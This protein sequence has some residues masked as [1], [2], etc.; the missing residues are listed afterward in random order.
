MN[1]RVSP[2]VHAAA[3]ALTSSAAAFA[4]P[5]VVQAQTAALSLPAMPLDQALQRITSWS[6]QSLNID[7]D[8]VRTLTSKPV[9]DAKS[10]EDAVRQATDGLPIARQR[11]DDGSLTIAN[12]IVVIASRDE[13]ETNVLVRGATTS[14]RLGQS[15]RDQARNTQVISSKLLEQQQARTL[16]E[17]LA[18][19]GG[20]TVNATTIQ[21]GVSYT[22]RGF[23]SNG[24]VNGLPTPSGSS[25]AAGTSQPMANIERLEVLKGPDAIL[26]GGDNL[27]GT[28]NIVTKRP[29]ADERLYVSAETGS[30]GMV[31]GTVD[32]NRA[33]SADKRW[34][35]RI[36]AT[37]ATASRNFGGY[38]GNEDYLFAPS[39]RFKNG[40]TD[41]VV[42][43]TIGNQIFGSVPYAIINPATKRPFALPT[44]RPVIGPKNQFVQIE[45]TQF[46][47]EVTQNVTDWLTV[48]VRGQHQETSFGLT[49]YSPFVLLAPTGLLL[50]SSQGVRQKSNVDAIDA[51]ARATFQ[52]GPLSH[53]IVAGHSRMYENIVAQNGQNGG[54]RPYNLFT[55][56]PPLP[57]LASVYSFSNAL[58]N[59][60]MGYY[61]QYL[62]GFGRLHLLAGVR[63]NRTRIR[64]EVFRAGK[65]DDRSNA[66]TP[67]YG[68]VVDV[69]KT[70]SVF[71]TLAYGF[72]PTFNLDRAGN[73]LPDVKTR[74]AEAGIKWDL[75]GERALL[76]ASWFNIRESNRIVSD[77]TNQQFQ[78]ALPGQQGRGIDINLSGEPLRGLSV[79]AAYT[80][81]NYRYLRPVA[82]LGNIV[83]GQP[84]DVYSLYTSYR[85]TLAPEVTA[86]LGAGVSGR[87]RSAIDRSGILYVP[88][89]VQADLNAFATAG[90][91][92]INLGVRNL[93]DRNNLLPTIASSFVPIG[94]PRNWRL[95]VGYKFR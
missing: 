69:T 65:T 91:F 95:T 12:D 4:S 6:G 21:S 92:D 7:P 53:K 26:L 35:A 32:A 56:A 11:G 38:R 46:S 9:V 36:V 63:H 88:A 57:T 18:N 74:N 67:N 71:G 61:A 30:F 15:L 42:S 31:R 45:A 70:L 52:T 17:A 33:I 20:V 66:T 81:T 82:T 59:E 85:Q 54:F 72:L 19:A 48:V 5:G 87:S 84:R 27:G 83:N 94:E 22:I 47:G 25:F 73:R 2:L 13:A 89:S 76:N 3:I 90:K 41:A 60:R 16:S 8:A 40:D 55:G 62:L 77:P 51:Y 29:S 1:Y 64:S 37:A 34:S 68:A 86:G 24:S 39:L 23:S 93:F 79:V 78:I 49:Q 50:V 28:V 10:A 75:F 58:D 80:R 43:A 14:S 44:G